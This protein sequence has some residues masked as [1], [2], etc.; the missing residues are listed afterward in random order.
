MITSCAPPLPALYEL[1]RSI[2]LTITTVACRV[3]HAIVEKEWKKNGS[4]R[5]RPYLLVAESM[6]SHWSSVLLWVLPLGRMLSADGPEG[7]TGGFGFIG[8]T[9][10][11]RGNL[12]WETLGIRKLLILWAGQLEG[13]RECTYVGSGGML[14]TVARDSICS[15]TNTIVRAST[16]IRTCGRARTLQAHSPPPLA[17]LHPPPFH[18]HANKNNTI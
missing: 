17:H 7:W 4:L 10:Q 8:Q 18:T 1:S 11:S 14:V 2:G 12:C 3:A 15:Y 5:H 6:H 13:R 16:N 9:V